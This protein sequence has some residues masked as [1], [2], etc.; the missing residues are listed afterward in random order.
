ME[1]ATSAS[2]TFQLSPFRVDTFYFGLQFQ[3][4]LNDLQIDLTLG[5][6]MSP[7]FSVYYLLHYKNSGTVAISNSIVKFLEPAL[8]S[9][10]DF[11]PAPTSLSGDT[12]LWNLGTLNPLDD[13]YIVVLDSV[14][15]TAAL[16]SLAVAKAWIEPLAGD[17]L[18]ADNESTST[19]TIIAAY[20][21][22][23]KSVSPDIIHPSYTGYL[24]YVIRFQNTGTDTAINVLLTD[25]LS[26][27]LNST[28]MQIISSSHQYVFWVENGV[29][30]WYFENILL[31]DSIAD[32]PGSHGFVKFRI[33]TDTN[34]NNGL[35][36]PN[37]ANIYFD[38]NTAVVTNT[39]IVNVSPLSV[40]TI[41]NEKLQNF[42]V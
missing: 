31:P 20:D 9:T 17:N 41:A 29:A 21:P 8:V 35:Q 1:T 36:I 22:N 38:F 26:N 25:T 13:G 19:D 42:W 18:A 12:L 5:D 40:K 28:T 27:F 23:H 16:G 10:I 34:L 6:F 24:E 7:G 11:Y 33:K 4:A 14:S 32:E 15:A 2:Q 39:I 30:K 3:P 37:S